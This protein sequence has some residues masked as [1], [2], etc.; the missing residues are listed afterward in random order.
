MPQLDLM[1]FF[2]QF[3]WF[4]VGF[5]FLYA[6]VIHITVPSIAQNLKFRK[7]K[8]EFLAKTVNTEKNSA[9]ELFKVYNSIIVRSFILWKVAFLKVVSLGEA[10]FE[11][12]PYLLN[13]IM[14]IEIQEEFIQTLIE[15]EFLSDESL[16]D[17]KMFITSFF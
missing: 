13:E 12:M 6:Y 1:H 11:E 2:S 4:S 3:F 8:L 10:W 17:R 9:A 5:T 7:K 14:F 15:S 16:A